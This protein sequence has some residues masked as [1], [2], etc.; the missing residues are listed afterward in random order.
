MTTNSCM[1]AFLFVN[2][3]MVGKD[4]EISLEVR[5]LAVDL[6]YYGYR[7]CETSQLL[8]LPY[9]CLTVLQY[10]QTSFAR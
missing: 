2:I 6:H 8:Q 5:K 10:Y 3:G 7:P 4:P 9:T 1:Q